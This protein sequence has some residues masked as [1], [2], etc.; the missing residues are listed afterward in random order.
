MNKESYYPKNTSL[1][2]DYWGLR[3]KYWLPQ[4]SILKLFQHSII[5][6]QLHYNILNVKSTYKIQ[7]HAY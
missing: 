3:K 7:V 1:S 2:E 5:K 4:I 6:S